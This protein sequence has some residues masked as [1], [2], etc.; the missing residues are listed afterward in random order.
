MSASQITRALGALE[1]LCAHPAGLPLQALADA[2]SMPKS[3]AHR[4]LAELSA[5]GYV[6]QN[7]ATGQYLLSTRLLSLAFGHLAVSG[8]ADV[9]QP[10]LERLAAHTGELVRLGVIDG[11]RQVWVAKAQ[12]AR[13]G[14]RYD[15]DMGR[16]APLSC[17]ASG[18]AWLACLDDDAAATLV[19]RQGIAKHDGLGPNAPRTLQAVLE[20]VRRA[21]RQGYASVVDSSAPGTSALAAALRHPGTGAVLG[22]VSVAGPS[23]RLTPER[24]EALAPE[25]LATAQE[26]ALAS[27]GST[28]FLARNAAARDP[29]SPTPSTSPH[30]P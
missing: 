16:E 15:P 7:R 4:T 19:A 13:S 26:L 24:I 5:L 10:L 20:R 2:L 17:T 23:V 30:H 3:A 6:V 28:Y 14:L 29:S 9:T 12:G 18:H 11:E 8:L 21:R 22:V 25:L 1:Q 27:A